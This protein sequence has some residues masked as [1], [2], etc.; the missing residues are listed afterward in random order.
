MSVSA[1]R[2]PSRKVECRARQRRYSEQSGWS[3]E[4]SRVPSYQGGTS[5]ISEGRGVGGRG[6]KPAGKEVPKGRHGVSRGVSCDSDS[7]QGP[8]SPRA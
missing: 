2:A 6:Q 3:S 1:A 5:S 4:S 7:E 8:L